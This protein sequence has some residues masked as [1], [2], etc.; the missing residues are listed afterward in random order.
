MAHRIYR[1]CS[2]LHCCIATDDA[3]LS[4]VLSPVS[5]ELT[6]SLAYRE[7]MSQRPLG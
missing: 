2:Q 7:G 4:A 6:L 1:T 3:I 5:P